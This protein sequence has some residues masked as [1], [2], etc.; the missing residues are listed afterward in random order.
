MMPLALIMS[1]H[2]R[3]PQNIIVFIDVFESFA[4]TESGKILQKCKMDEQSFFVEI[5]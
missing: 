5:I 1:E 3:K 4:H 2:Q